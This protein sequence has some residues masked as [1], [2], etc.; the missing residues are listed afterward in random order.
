VRWLPT[1]VVYR[2][3]GKCKWEMEMFICSTA[4]QYTVYTHVQMCV[5]KCHRR[6]RKNECLVGLQEGCVKVVQYRTM[7]FWFG[8]QCYGLIRGVPEFRR[9]I[10]SPCSEC[11]PACGGNT[12]LWISGTVITPLYTWQILQE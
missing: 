12:F 5:K 11:N 9:S 6:C 7:L 3:G 8:A 2:G 4:V 1:R 10:L